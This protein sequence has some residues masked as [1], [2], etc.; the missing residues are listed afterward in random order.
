MAACVSEKGAERTY[1]S[2]RKRLSSTTKR[3]SGFPPTL[4]RQS[5][6]IPEKKLIQRY[7][8]FTCLWQRRISCAVVGS[9]P[10]GFC[11]Y[12]HQFNKCS[13]GGAGRFINQP[14]AKIM[15]MS[16]TGY[17]LGVKEITKNLLRESCDTLYEKTKTIQAEEYH[18]AAKS[19]KTTHQ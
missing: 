18:S 17:N 9:L 6:K 19:A 11:V 14:F 15:K 10:S 8:Q 13:Q 4:P 3:G 5:Q 16:E 7:S 2:T 12:S 1:C